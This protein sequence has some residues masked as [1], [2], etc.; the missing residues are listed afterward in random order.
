ME[1]VHGISSVQNIKASI[2]LV[3]LNNLSKLMVNV[4]SN[5]MTKRVF[6][7]LCAETSGE[8]HYS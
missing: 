8:F 3:N 7:F 2:F 1:E 5:F 4:S 6:S